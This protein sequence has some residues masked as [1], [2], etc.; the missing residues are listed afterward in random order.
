MFRWDLPLHRVLCNLET[1]HLRL[2]KCVTY[3][4]SPCLRSDFYILNPLVE[5]V[6]IVWSPM[7]G[8]PR[9]KSPVYITCFITVALYCVIITFLLVGRSC[10][11]ST[12]LPLTLEP[13]RARALP[14]GK[15]F[16]MHDRP[17]TLLLN[18]CTVV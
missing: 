9:F 17:K 1:S 2:L 5:K 7:A 15:G 18:P 4:N 14:Q 16:S 8:I 10:P 12:F 11:V 6:H 3:H 13:P